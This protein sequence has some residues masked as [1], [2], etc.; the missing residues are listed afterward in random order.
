MIVTRSCQVKGVDV[1][2]VSIAFASKKIT[3][4]CLSVT[5]IV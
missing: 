3:T 1:V 4:L 2:N 5:T